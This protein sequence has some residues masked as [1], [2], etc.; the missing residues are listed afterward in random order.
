MGG[1]TVTVR[2]V[3]DRNLSIAQ[4][5]RANRLGGVL[6]RLEERAEWTPRATA[7]LVARFAACRRFRIA[8][9]GGDFAV[10]TADDLKRIGYY[11]DAMR[12]R[13]ERHGEPVVC[14][15]PR[16]VDLGVSP[17]VVA[18]PR[19]RRARRHVARATSSADGP[20]GEPAEP[21]EPVARLCAGGGR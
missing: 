16:P 3:P 15:R 2:S 17:T 18:R 4:R 7:V 10:L 6:I 21:P 20:A 1:I 19:E 9:A 8:I 11:G 12:R 13:A 5:A 14:M